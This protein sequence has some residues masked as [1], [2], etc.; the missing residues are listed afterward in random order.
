MACFDSTNHCV[1]VLF[2]F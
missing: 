2:C 1:C